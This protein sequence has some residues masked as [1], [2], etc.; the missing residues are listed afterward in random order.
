MRYDENRVKYLLGLDKTNDVIEELIVLNYGLMQK[1]IK[2]FGMY[3]DP[4]AL[5]FAYESLYKAI[6]T[7]NVENKHKFSTYA[8]V[9]IYNRLGSYVR[10]IKTQI[11]LNTLSYESTVSEDGKTLLDTFESKSTA[12][13]ELLSEC[14]IQDVYEAIDYCIRS[15]TN[16]LHR[17]IVSIWVETDFKA[18][19][20]SIAKAAGCTQSY[21]SQVIRI[22][23]STL[24]KKLGETQ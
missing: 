11:V 20:T 14:G 24:K 10:S 4:D 3:N 6:I 16:P 8:T 1:Q 22:F 5:S 7:Y 15:T 17:M 18:S 21:V 19:Y 12:D 13:G 9:C 23:K 2:K